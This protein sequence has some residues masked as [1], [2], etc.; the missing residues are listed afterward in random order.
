M[1]PRTFQSTRHG[2]PPLALL[3]AVLA[4]LVLLALSTSIVSPTGIG[5]ADR[6]LRAPAGFAA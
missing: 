1:L 3:A 6:P 2:S 5:P 4:V